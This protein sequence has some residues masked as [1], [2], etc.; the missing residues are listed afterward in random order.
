M[1]GP[2]EMKALVYQYSTNMVAVLLEPTLQFLERMK[3]VCSSSKRLSADKALLY[4]MQ[5][6]TASL[7]LAV[8]CASILSMDRESSHG[9]GQSP[10]WEILADLMKK[11]ESHVELGPQD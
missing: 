5:L 11:K 2:P 3:K 6:T 4:W 10:L 8:W 7:V 9:P 1:L